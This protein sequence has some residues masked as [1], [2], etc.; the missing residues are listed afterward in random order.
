M[1]NCTSQHDAATGSFQIG[2]T[3]CWANSRLGLHHHK[4][5]PYKADSDDE[6]AL[7]HVAKQ[8]QPQ[9]NSH[10]NKHRLSSLAF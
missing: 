9:L 5:D 3:D 8:Q 1:Y 10:Y 7:L 2:H 4:H 6:E